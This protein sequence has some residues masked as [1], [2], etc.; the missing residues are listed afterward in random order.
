MGPRRRQ[1]PSQPPIP[2]STAIMNWLVPWRLTLWAM[3]LLTSAS[4]AGCAALDLLGGTLPGQDDDSQPV[5]DPR[6]YPGAATSSQRPPLAETSS[7][8]AAAAAPAPIV[9]TAE[10]S[11][12]TST[13][14]KQAPAY[15]SLSDD[16]SGS[17]AA[18]PQPPMTKPAELPAA[19][20]TE[21]ATAATAPAAPIGE[22]ATPA[23][24]AKESTP[25]PP[26]V[27]TKT[28]EKK[29]P[30]EPAKAEPTPAQRLADILRRRDE[31]VAALQAEVKLR[32]GQQDPDGE[33]PRMQ[34]QLR[35]LYLLAE[36]PDDAASE[37]ESLPEA[38]QEAFKQLM[39]GLSTWLSPEEERRA[40]LRNARVLRS[41]R[42]AAA[43]LSAAAKLDVR[44]LRFCESVDGYGWY[45][46]FPTA[47]FRPKQQVILYAEVDNFAMEKKG[48]DTYETELKASY[49]IF[50][51]N[52]TLVDERELPLDKE[53]CR[54]PRRDYF[55]AYRIY[56]P[57]GLAAGR[58]RLELTVEDLK[59]KE[60]YQGR[61]LGDGVIEFSIR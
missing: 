60:H 6:P 42:D 30:D 53:M 35:L 54:N 13:A 20:K 27:T 58:Y 34:Q 23:K 46:E 25:Q 37:I 59:A 9:S 22:T 5:V 52:G 2:V 55:L 36:K 41:L 4:L 49:Q 51:G 47:Q 17:P 16:P 8:A 56:L 3:P 44:N 61:K 10:K 33:L 7:Q 19:A 29:S 28:A 14:G 38:E 50:D 40:N 48:P 12:R 45:K 1:T 26:D 18:H 11:Q 57:D 31:L 24:V 21:T 15:A 43:Q 32:S 39:F